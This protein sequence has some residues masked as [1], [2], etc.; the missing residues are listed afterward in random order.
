MTDFF[1]PDVQ[2]LPR[3]QLR[4]LQEER[5]RALVHR[6]FEQPIP[7]F[8]DKMKAAGLDPDDIKS[9]DDLPRIPRTVKQELR[10]NEAANPPLGTYRGAP[11]SQSIRL[12]TSTGTTG[13]PTVIT[14]TKHD[15]DVEYE[16]GCRSFMRQGRAPGQVITHA[17]PGGLN[18]GQAL[19]GGVIEAFGSLNV[20][21]GL[22]SSQDDIARAIN[23][24]RELKPDHYEMFGPV[25]HIF[26]EAAKGM[27]L[28]PEKDLNMKPPAD[29]PQ[30]RAVSAGLDAFAFLGSACENDRGSHMCEDE[31]IVEAVDNA[32]GEPVP[33]GTR[34]NLVVTTL[35]K[36]NAMLRYDLEDVVRIERD[37]CLCGE[38]HARA[39]WEGRRADIVRAAGKEI[40]PNDVH[41]SLSDMAEL[42][43]PAL[44]F[45]MVRGADQT[46]LHVRVEAEQPSDELATRVRARL[47][48]R[49]GVPIGLHLLETGKL[50]RPFYKPLR[51]V[52]E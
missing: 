31:A 18:G 52:D 28:D 48:E 51:V 27:G 46:T 34:G 1:R 25:L 11:V 36:D 26:W 35:T 45:Q 9:L 40:L 22:P 14:F 15:L 5:L 7:F 47:E 20:P 13:R 30:Y 24:W 10:D 29:I 21:V 6:I 2:A 3:E 12:S 17:H 32:T 39:Y 23:L 16:A 4:A 44:E 37:P 49:L 50:P 43:R 41:M 42:A 33:D 38:T 8:R 19:L